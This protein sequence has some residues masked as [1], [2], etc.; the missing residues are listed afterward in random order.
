MKHPITGRLSTWSPNGYSRAVW[1][2][3][4]PLIRLGIWIHNAPGVNRGLLQLSRRPSGWN[5]RLWRLAVTRKRASPST[6]QA[7]PERSEEGLSR[8]SDRI[9][10]LGAVLSFAFALAALAFAW[11]LYFQWLPLMEF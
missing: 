2:Q 8:L 3:L 9:C 11:W 6:T 7:A 4:H 1:L 5:L 10:I